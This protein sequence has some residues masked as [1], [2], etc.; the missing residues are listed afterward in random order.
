MS[1]YPDHQKSNHFG[2]LRGFTSLKHLSA[3][4]EAL[5]AGCCHPPDAVFRLK[6]VLPPSLETLTIDA[7]EWY[8]DI[9]DL[10]IQLQE[11]VDSREFPFL[12]SLILE[13]RMQFNGGVPEYQMQ[14]KALERACQS[15]K[16][17][18]RVEKRE[19]L[20]VGGS[21][22]ENWSESIRMLKASEV[23]I[24]PFGLPKIF[25]NIE[26]TVVYCDGDDNDD[27][28]DNGSDSEG[29]YSL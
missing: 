2:S 26:R 6:D 4:D 19:A 18:L 23:Q 7:R 21:Q 12:E 27:N 15:K 29:E 22:Q 1:P 25:E 13:N 17:S 10:L 3:P 9:D 16:L 24:N 20:P 8:Q 28:D 14:Y 5:L 11:V